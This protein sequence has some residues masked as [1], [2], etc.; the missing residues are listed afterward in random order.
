MVIAGF[1]IENKLGKAQF[2]EESFLLA[3]TS[4]EVVLRMPFLILSNANIQ[5]A[6]KEFICR[7]YTTAEALPTTKQV[8][9]IDKKEFAKVVLDEEFETFVM[10]IADL[11]TLLEGIMIHL[12][13]K[14]KFQH[15][16]RMRLLPKFYPN[17][18]TMLRYFSST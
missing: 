12:H 3:D 7:S 13:E 5:F 8:E 2:F 9:L 16:F 14:L 1:Q 15:Q 6:K 18:Q 11:E 4:I 10:H 17:T